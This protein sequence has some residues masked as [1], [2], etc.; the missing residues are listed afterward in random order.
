MKKGIKVWK[1]IRGKG[2]GIFLGNQIMRPYLESK[3]NQDL[4]GV[5]KALI[6]ERNK[7]G[8]SVEI[9]FGC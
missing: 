2:A 3:I 7:D 1:K 9:K 8:M 4:D 6:E 5:V